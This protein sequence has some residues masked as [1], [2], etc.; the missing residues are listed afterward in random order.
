MHLAGDCDEGILHLV[1]VVVVGGWPDDP[2]RLLSG[3]WLVGRA[4]ELREAVL[5]QLA[6]LAEEVSREGNAEAA[7]LVNLTEGLG[8]EDAVGVLALDSHLKA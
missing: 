8:L 4:V 3:A 1:V 2:R 5:L 7:G 6:I